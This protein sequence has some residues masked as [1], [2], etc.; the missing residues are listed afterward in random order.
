LQQDNLTAQQRASFRRE[1][2]ITRSLNEK[3]A[4]GVITV[5]DFTLL[6]NRETIVLEDIGAES[7]SRYIAIQR[8]TPE[9]FIELALRILETIGRVHGE[10]IIHKDINPANIVYNSDTGELR[11]IDF[12]I[13]SWLP[14]EAPQL[15]SVG[16]LEGTMAYISP[17]QTGRMNRAVDYRSDFYSLG[18]TFYQMLTGWLPFQSTDKSELVHC[19]ITREATPAS[20]SAPDVPQMLSAIIAKL[21]AKRAEERYQ[22]VSGIQHDLEHC[23]SEIK[24]TRVIAPFA[25]GNMDF[26]DK[27]AIPQKLYGREKDVEELLAKYSCVTGGLMEM[28][29]VAGYAGVG[30]SSLVYELHR[31]ISESGGHFITG[32]FD[33]LKRNIPYSTFIQAF[34]EMVQHILSETPDELESW[35]EKIQKALGPMAGLSPTSFPILSLSSADSPTSRSWAPPRRRTDSI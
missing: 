25:I 24:A 30:K 2:E 12:G 27:L 8:P 6:N 16:R 33:Q 13:S 9:N 23:L 20:E 32:K 18:V 21:M 26:S 35:K 29:M 19:H 34:N 15:T 11:L 31:P 22:S 14:R 28:A 4:A 5:Y 7:L 17:E 3:K 10:N 1:Y